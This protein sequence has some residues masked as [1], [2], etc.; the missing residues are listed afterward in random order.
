MRYR[1]KNSKSDW[2]TEEC[3]RE[4]LADLKGK[5]NKNVQNM[6]NSARPI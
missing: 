5:K 3:N 1:V 4:R 2:V 6:N